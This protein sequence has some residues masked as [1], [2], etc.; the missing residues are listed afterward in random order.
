MKHTL[1]SLHCHYKENS[2]VR[3]VTQKIVAD[4]GFDLRG[5]GLCQRGEGG[6]ARVENH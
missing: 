2:W 3:K 4:P 6:G 1:L 5:R